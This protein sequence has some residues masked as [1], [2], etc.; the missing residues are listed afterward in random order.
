MGN[1]KVSI[2]EID[3]VELEYSQE[4]DLIE[5]LNYV[6]FTGTGFNEN[7]I[8]VDEL[9]RVLCDQNGNVLIGV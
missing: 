8:L 2:L 9:F 5:A 3:G 6:G 1:I 4:M 7:L